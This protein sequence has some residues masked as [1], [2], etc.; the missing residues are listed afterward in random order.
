MPLQ[1]L[2]EIKVEGRYNH[3]F[4]NVR[5]IWRQSLDWTRN[6]N[7]TFTDEYHEEYSEYCSAREQY[8]TNEERIA[9]FESACNDED[10]RVPFEEK[11]NDYGD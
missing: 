8:N 1:E 6:V 11:K 3:K 9:E 7:G 2:K 10:E 4:Q 5:T